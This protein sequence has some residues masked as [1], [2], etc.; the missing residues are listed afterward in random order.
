MRALSTED[1]TKC[2]LKDKYIRR[3]FGGVWPINKVPFSKFKNK[4]MIINTDPHY[5]KGK[6]WFCLFIPREKKKGENIKIEIF[7]SLGVRNSKKG[8]LAYFIRKLQNR[9]SIIYNGNRLQAIKSSYCGYYCLLF[10]I[11]RSRGIK[12]KNIVKL[13]KKNSNWNDSFVRDLI[14]NYFPW[15]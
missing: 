8:W 1:L 7:C 3:K 13:F 4:I 9:G 6:H 2:M 10:A 11:M 14:T 12:F 5:K 15:V